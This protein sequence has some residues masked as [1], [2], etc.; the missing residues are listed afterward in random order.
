MLTVPFGRY[1]WTQTMNFVDI[2]VL[3]PERVT[4]ARQLVVKY[5]RDTLLVSVKGAKEPIID[6]KLYGPLRV[7]DCTWTIDDPDGVHEKWESD[8]EDSSDDERTPKRKV[9]HL[10]LAKFDNDQITKNVQG[11]FW[12][13][14]LKEGELMPLPKSLPPDY[15]D[16]YLNDRD[17]GRLW[18]D[19]A[20][21]DN[22]KFG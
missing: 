21:Q 22:R 1:R 2:F 8:S 13:G 5:T 16:T 10:E 6:G 7:D 3:L 9:L 20:R 12:L 11:G 15:Y 18:G 17:A 4:K 19:G 14:V